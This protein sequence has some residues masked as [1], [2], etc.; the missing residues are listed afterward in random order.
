MRFFVKIT[1]FL[2]FNLIFDNDGDKMWEYYVRLMTREL[3]HLVKGERVYIQ[4]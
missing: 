2:P 4:W 3:Y 1:K